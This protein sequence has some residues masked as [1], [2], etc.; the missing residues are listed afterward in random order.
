MRGGIHRT[1]QCQGI[2]ST[3]TGLQNCALPPAEI[4]LQR[5]DKSSI[6]GL[7]Q[8][9]RPVRRHRPY[10]GKAAGIT[11]SGGKARIV[12]QKCHRAFR[13]KSLVSKMFVRFLRDDIHHNGSLPVILCGTLKPEFFMQWRTAT[14]CQNNQPGAQGFTVAEGKFRGILS[15]A[16]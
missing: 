15:A 6:T 1:L 8:G 3:L 11:V 13:G 16:H 9:F 10:N 7:H 4:I 14:I 5:L 2:R 12:R